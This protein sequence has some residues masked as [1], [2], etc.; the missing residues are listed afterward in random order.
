MKELLFTVTKKDCDWQYF[1]TGGH[2]GQHR[3]KTSNGV[4]VVHRLSGATGESTEFRE[5]YENKK[6][7]FKKMAESPRFRNWCKQ[8]AARVTG[9]AA[10]LEKRVDEMMRDENLLIEYGVYDE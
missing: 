4:R 10:E 5:Q 3:D 9:Q 6:A 8:E 7:A 2:G 1:R